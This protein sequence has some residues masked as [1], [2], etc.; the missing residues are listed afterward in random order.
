MTKGKPAPG[1]RVRVEKGGQAFEGVLMPS[2]GSGPVVKLD[3]G[4]NV[5]AG[6]GAKVAL[7]EKAPATKPAPPKP[8][9]AGGPARTLSILSTGGT[10]A[11]RVDYRTGAVTS[12]FSAGDLVQAIPELK[13]VA[14]LGAE[15]VFSILSEN[16]TPAR[17]LVLAKKI[18]GEIRKGAD[19]VLVTHGTDTMGY[20]AAALSFL[21]ETPVPVVLTGA[22]RSSDRPSSDA[23]VNAVCA[24]EAAMADFAEVAVVMHA[25]TADGVCAIHRGTRVRKG[26]TSR[27]DAFESQPGPLGLVEFASRK[28]EFFLDRRPRGGEL[29]TRL[30]M[31]PRVALVKFAPGLGPQVLERAAQGARGVVLEGT[32]LGHVASSWTPAVRKL[33]KRGVPVVMASQCLRGRVNDRVYD[34]GRDLLK[35]GV[36]EAEDMLPE[37]AYVKLMWVLGQTSAPG[38]VRRLMQTNL[39]GEITGSSAQ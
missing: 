5:G 1:D 29:K 23:A 4:Y 11:S 37:T 10:I 16:M 7:L 20:T 8:L 22:Q 31:E 14:R 19:G 17:W 27:R 13:E 25:G 21:L 36:I 3:S 33:S 28:V 9:P 39:A 24:A 15:P 2:P 12:Q 35:A 18:A 30:K 38:E 6:P 26:H 34:T 32:G